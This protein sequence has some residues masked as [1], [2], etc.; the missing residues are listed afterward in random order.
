[1]RPGAKG[2]VKLSSV[3]CLDLLAFQLKWDGARHRHGLPTDFLHGH[4]ALTW[5]DVDRKR[6]L[7]IMLAKKAE[8][9]RGDH[10]VRSCRSTPRSKRF[11]RVPR[12]KQPGLAR[13]AGR[14]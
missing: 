2:A 9:R 10:A 4:A 3:E 13:M 6:G 12:K 1:M 8:H 7:P 14:A 11:S 5:A